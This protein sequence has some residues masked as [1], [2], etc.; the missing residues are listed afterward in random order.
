MLRIA[1]ARRRRL[2]SQEMP[3][4]TRRA[5]VGESA[6]SVGM[7]STL[8]ISDS[9]RSLEHRTCDYEERRAGKGTMLAKINVP[10]NVEVG[11]VATTTGEAR[12]DDKEK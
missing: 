10:A 2:K 4:T 12:G 5:E 3:P 1:G 6:T 8:R 11:L 9:C 7:R